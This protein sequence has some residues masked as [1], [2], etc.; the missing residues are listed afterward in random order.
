NVPLRIGP[1]GTQTLDLNFHVT[2]QS[3][4]VSDCYS[5]PTQGFRLLDSAALKQ[6]GHINGL[7]VQGGVGV[8]LLN[9]SSRIVINVGLPNIFGFAPGK[10]AQGTMC[11]NLDNTNGLNLDGA[12]IG[13]IP[14][15]FLG[16]I[17]LQDLTFRYLKEDDV[18]EGGATVTFPGSPV[19]IDASPPPPDLGF[20]LKDG[21]FDHAGIGLDFGPGAQP[22]LFPGVFLTNI[23]VAL[24]TDP[25]RFTGGIGLTAA[26]VLG[27]TGD[28][29]VAFASAD[30]PYAFPSSAGDLAPLSGRT[31]SSFT[32][33]VGGNATAHL[34]I[35]GQMPLA[36]AYLLYEFPDYF[37]LG[38][39]FAYE[40]PILKITGSM[41]GFLDPPQHAFNLQGSVSACLRKE[42][43]ISVGPIDEDIKPC[44]TAGAVVSSKGIA[45]CGTVLVPAPIVGTVPVPIVVGY[46]W[47]D[48]L[49]SITPSFSCNMGDYQ[50]ASSHAARASGPPGFSLPSRL[51][52]ATVRLTGS[53][54][55]PNAVLSGPGGLRVSTLGAPQRS[56]VVVVHIPGAQETLIALRRPPAGRWTV[57]VAPGSTPIADVAVA[58]SLPAPKIRVRV[59][60]RGRRR[61]LRY[62]MVAGPGRTVSFAERAPGVYRPLGA[63]HGAHGRIVFTPAPGRSGRRE[64]LAL[65]SQ[66]GL[67]VARAV[68]GSFQAPSRGR[69]RATRHL[70]ARRTGTGLAVSWRGVPGSWRYAATL[71]LD[72]GRRELLLSRGPH[73]TFTAVSPTAGGRVQ[74][75]ALAAD[76]RRGRA[77]GVAFA[78]ARRRS[79]RGRP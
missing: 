49:P 22:Q 29:F 12:K 60:E 31:L 20:G 2:L 46:R 35:A 65:I 64:I 7:P 41:L 19:S 26:Q 18:W 54:G 28:V 14:N 47:G 52:A 33:A 3:L 72:D 61:T 71:T 56:D 79:R 4:P 75:V 59:T 39:G 25:L 6:E 63:A 43:H 10:P 9:H 17:A 44:L 68:V 37:E 1:L 36:N 40:P 45:F 73:V 74:V 32:I 69:L 57:S 53:G 55:A 13:P 16:P 77:A 42:I 48:G 24:G 5:R 11:L 30:Q 23:H 34:P 50:V 21:R 66:G 15:T 62:R 38:G 27:I 67:P 58:P 51:A 8:D 76:G 78:P 70:R